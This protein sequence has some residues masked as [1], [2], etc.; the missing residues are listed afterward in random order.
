MIDK[1]STTETAPEEVE[2]SDS[3]NQATSDNEKD[4]QTW[5]FAVDLE[6]FSYPAHV[7]CVTPDR[8]L[9][10]DAAIFFFPLRNKLLRKLTAAAL[11]FQVK[12]F[13]PDANL[14]VT[15]K[16]AFYAF[17]TLPRKTPRTRATSLPT[18]CGFA[19]LALFSFA[20]H[21]FFRTIRC[22][23]LLNYFSRAFLWKNI[24]TF[25]AL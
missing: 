19:L 17:S 9:P 7:V 1:E 5:E 14:P 6:L 10:E 2:E 13:A 20:D 3:E 12:T 24:V 16:L 21:I 15:W 4:N 11:F 23:S 22:I 18:F 25:Y 8:C